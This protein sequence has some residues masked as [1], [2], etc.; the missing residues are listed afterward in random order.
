M[1][2]LVAA[3]TNRFWSRRMTRF[4]PLILAVLIAGGIV[5]AYFVI[6]NNR[7]QIDFVDDMAGGTDASSILGPLGAL[8][9]VM[10]FVIGASSIGADI[11]TGM[12]EQLLT[13]EP[14]RIRL[15]AVRAV[16]VGFGVAVLAALLAALL[17]G[18]SFL[19]AALTGTTDGTTGEVWVNIAFA[20]L[21]TGGAAGLFAVFGV[22][23][24]LLVNSSVGS[25][26]GF[27]IY[28]FIVENLLLS[29]FLPRI[30]VYTPVTNATVFAQ[31]T[32]VQRIT[33]GVFSEGGPTLVDEHS[34]SVAAAI[35]LAWTLVVLA[36][37]AVA[38]RGH[39][40]D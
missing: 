4:F 40:I 32:P 21:R 23:V 8:L 15:L 14:R 28:W 34:A 36:A 6:E 22:S 13:W 30:V 10:A 27:V 2:A 37:S 24:T 16:A 11:K 1:I 19:L 25:I 29:A 33:G 12:L 38:F 3:E 7:T 18:L 39:D 35:L 26:V 20:V 5:I 17:A 31:G 9:P